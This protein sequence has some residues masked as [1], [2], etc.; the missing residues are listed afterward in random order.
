MP[1][2]GRTYSTPLDRRQHTWT[3]ADF[4]AIA[5]RQ[6]E[7]EDLAARRADRVLLCDT[8]AM[9]TAMWHEQY[10]GHRADELE[11][12]AD[13]RRHYP[14]TIV[15]DTD[16]PW[17]QDGDRRSVAARRA[18]QA[19]LLERLALRGESYVVASG[20]IEERLDTASVAIERATGIRPTND[21]VAWAAPGTGGQ[22]ALP[23]GA[24]ARE[25]V[26]RWPSAT[27]PLFAGEAR[28]A[29]D[30]AGTDYE[31]GAARLGLTV[32]ALREA[33][34]YAARHDELIDAE[35]RVDTEEIVELAARPGASV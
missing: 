10:L 34:W 26:A 32:P 12:Y 9:V 5:R 21:G 14:L 6:A 17:V 16:I 29:L 2:H 31:L 28:D 22:V 35:R 7:L 33:D 23:G 4:M 20:S 15:A 18:Q 19:D 1:E 8:D 13:A 11:A 24:A 3:T 30:E 27:P 25:R